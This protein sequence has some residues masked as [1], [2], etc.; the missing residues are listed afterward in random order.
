MNHSDSSA[1]S[2]AAQPRQHLY[3]LECGVQ[4]Y[5]WGDTEFIPALLG[6]DNPDHEPFAE[7]WMGAHVDL[8]SQVRIDG[9][10]VGLNDLIAQA[11]Q[12]ILGNRVARQFDHQLPYLFKVLSTAAPLSIQSH[13]SKKQAEVG[14]ARENEAGIP[15]SAAYRNYKDDNHKPELIAALTDY[16]GLRG[17]RPLVQIAKVLKSIPEMREYAGS[18]EP[19]RR[20]LDNLYKKLMSLPQ[21]EVDHILD[22]LV[23]RLTASH[24]KK[25]FTPDQQEYWVLEAD[26]EFAIGAHHDRGL[27][28]I[29]LLNLVYLKPGEAMYLPAGILHAYLNG[30]GMEVMANSNNVLRGGLTV[31]HVDVPELI[32]N[33]T[34]EG[35]DVEVLSAKRIGQTPEWRYET[36]ADEFELRCIELDGTQVYQSDSDH[37]ADILILV[38]AG[39]STTVTMCC[40]DER[41][42]LQTGSVVLAIQGS[43]YTVHASAQATLYK[44][45]VPS[46]DLDSQPVHFRG[47]RPKR[48]SFGT[49]GLRG[50]VDDITDLEAYVNTRGF[51]QYLLDLNQ[52]QPGDKV[53]IGGDL[54]PSTDSPN[55]SI[56]RACGRAIEDAGLMADHLG[57]LPTPALAFYALQRHQ[58]SVMVTGS[59]IPFDRNGIKFN[60]PAGEVLKSD[61][62]AI[63]DAVVRARSEQ[64]SRG[65]HQSAFADDGMLKLNEVRMLPPVNE[66]AGKTY[67][68]RYQQFFRGPGL[69]GQRIVVFEHSMVGRK[70]LVEL[71]GTLGAE[72]VPMGRS[73][74]FVAIDTEDISA[75]QVGAIQAMADAA[76]SQVGRVDAVVSTDGD[77]DR[78]LVCG[79]DSTGQV[80]LFGGDL[81][82]VAVAEYLEAD[83]V[84][85]P[86]S[87]NDA[88]DLQLAKRGMVA[89]KTRIGSP[90][91]IAAMQQALAAGKRRVVGWEANGGFMVGSDIRCGNRVLK[92]LPTRDAFLPILAALFASIE[93]GCSVVELFDKFPRRFGKAGLIDGYPQEVSQA[94]VRRFSI[95][96]QQQVVEVQY[97]Q[98]DVNACNGEGCSVQL[99]ATE[100]DQAGRIRCALEGYFHVHDGFGA[101][102]K[103]NYIDGVRIH[104]DNGDIA[105]VRPSGNAP[106]LRLYAVADNSD[107]A[108]QIV[109]MGISGSDGILRRMGAA[110]K[111]G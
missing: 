24:A 36:P 49:S 64:Y 16:Y 4:H 77:S 90:Y 78:P 32:S 20:G 37:S 50:L 13:P 15:R 8:P 87:A 108:G 30:T 14:F 88:V 72:V 47:R 95:C 85:L 81:L 73:E 97:A 26:R 53:C 83:S 107:R 59:H 109:A 82:G 39:S 100:L 98:G 70:L 19:T 106:Q 34:F 68:Q 57:R 12:A 3:P 71:L 5:V 103:I 25:P 105:H 51:L 27:F 33:V 80:H 10:M 58:A 11:P 23:R 89:T 45:V 46:G 99:T 2:N 60:Q 91:V 79:V 48:L 38:K 31:K 86:I 56:M 54:R 55:R 94:L 42:D 9:H 92:E 40:G 7:L 28:S 52:V 43:P 67:L 41:L 69:G 44:A 104:F 84:S 62:P 61:E 18:F 102:T 21:Q 75:D 35:G 93:Q 74:Q 22:P 65:K 101:I 111:G 6:Q 63:L 1:Q 110:L 29:F 96:S 17:F 76:S 66:R